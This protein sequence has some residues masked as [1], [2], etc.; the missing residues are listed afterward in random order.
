MEFLFKLSRT[1]LYFFLNIEISNIWHLKNKEKS[2]LC[3]FDETLHIRP[4]FN[5][6]S[7]G[8]GFRSEKLPLGGH[9]GG[10]RSICSKIDIGRIASRWKAYDPRTSTTSILTTPWG[11]T[12]VKYRLVFEKDIFMNF[13]T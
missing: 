1:C 6:E 13:R 10:Q 9:V 2:R 12:G 8:K 4:I 7:N 3:Y 5:Q 11:H